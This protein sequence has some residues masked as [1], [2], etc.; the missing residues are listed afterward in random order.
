M[1]ILIL[2]NDADEHARHVR[3]TI[4]T[5]GR[6]VEFLDSTQ[7]PAQLQIALDP[8]T[9]D[10]RLRFP[11][12]LSLDFAQIHSVYW[13]SYAGVGS[14]RL[15]D[16]EQSMIANNDAR[17]LFESFLLRLPARWVNGWRAFQ[18]H[19]TKPT[20]LAIVAGLGIPVPNTLVGND[21]DSVRKFVARNPCC[22]FKP[23]QGGAFTERVRAEHLTDENLR[24][25]CLA[26]VTI[27]EEIEGVDVRVF[28]AG[29]RVLACEVR[30]ATLDFRND[31]APQIVPI[32][33]PPDVA[34]AS[35]RIARALD[36][37]WTGIDFR[38]TFDGQYVF[39][40]ANPSPMFL[41]FESRSG[42]RLTE[43]LVSLLTA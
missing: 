8:A 17:S 13:R 39:L 30:A 40:E 9:G 29:E 3:D 12:G 18:L 15:P 1:T 11:T 2:G 16:P 14:I 43:E 37:V 4:L 41:G 31:P 34:V 5:R 21:P 22:I 42:L 23:V 6:P 33:L 35:L 25:L 24:N 20:A 38:R 10:G 32:D 26:P 36:L 19:Q 27:Q 28:V 7:F